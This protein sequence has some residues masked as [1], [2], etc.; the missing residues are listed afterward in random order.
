MAAEPLNLDAQPLAEE[1]SSDQDLAPVVPFNEA[2]HLYRRLAESIR[3]RARGWSPTAISLLRQRLDECF[4]DDLWSGNR[5]GAL[6]EL[7]DIAT[8]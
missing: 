2:A 5:E 1:F 3:G 8:S 7:I 4:G 6:D